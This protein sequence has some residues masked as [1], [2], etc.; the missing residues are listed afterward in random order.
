MV[1]ENVSKGTREFVADAVL[2]GLHSSHWGPLCSTLETCLLPHHRKVCLQ[3]TLVPLDFSHQGLSNYSCYFFFTRANNVSE[4]L[5]VPPADAVIATSDIILAALVG[6]IVVSLNDNAE[7]G[8]LSHS[9]PGTLA[10]TGSPSRH[11][12]SPWWV[13]SSFSSLE[14]FRKTDFRVGA[15]SWNPK[16][17]SYLGRDGVPY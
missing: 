3:G 13:C 15:L 12:R 5:S 16:M 2:Q 7:S 8:A 1:D 14:N 11:Q 9:W 6:N 4:I 10:V 17:L